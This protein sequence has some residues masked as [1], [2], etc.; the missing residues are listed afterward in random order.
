MFPLRDQ[1]K[2]ILHRIHCGSTCKM[3]RTHIIHPINTNDEVQM[4]ETHVDIQIVYSLDKGKY[5]VILSAEKQ[6]APF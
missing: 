4:T 2:A 3:H 6:N 5:T 1:L